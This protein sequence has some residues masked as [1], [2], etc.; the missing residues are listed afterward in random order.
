MDH[1]RRLVMTILRRETIVQQIG[2]TQWAGRVGRKPGVD[3]LHVE[4]M[5]ALWDKPEHV[6]GLKLT[7]AY[8]AVERVVPRL[9]DDLVHK[10]GDGIN[11]GLVKSRIVEMKQLPQL[12]LECRDA[13]LCGILPVYSGRQTHKEPNDEMEEVRMEEYYS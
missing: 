11:E 3:A 1:L 6:L 8:S 9:D 7:Q 5:T 12:A 4:G 2:P 10:Q 13:T